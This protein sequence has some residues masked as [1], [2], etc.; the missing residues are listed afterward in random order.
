MA[1]PL[2][3]A[4]VQAVELENFAKGI[5]DLVYKG[6]TFYNLIKKKSKT[7]PTS[8]TTQAGGTSR[9]SFRIP[10]RIQSGAA[11]FQATGNGDALG[12]GTGSNWVAGDISPIGLFA[13]TEIT[14]F[15]RITTSCPK[16]SLIS[17]RP[18]DVKKSFHT[19]IQRLDPPFFTD[20]SA[21]ILHSPHT[22]PGI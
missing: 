20:W 21:T 11:I 7:F 2:Q 4:A 10:V 22:P 6:R 18:E 14:Y 1:S 8:V 19:L 3:E 5:P 16:H 13:G 15:A 12:R 17:P 9:P